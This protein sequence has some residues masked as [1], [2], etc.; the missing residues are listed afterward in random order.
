VGSKINNPVQQVIINT[1]GSFNRE[2]KWV[3]INSYRIWKLYKQL[4]YQHQGNY[5]MH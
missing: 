4:V 2:N 1:R 5:G 3:G